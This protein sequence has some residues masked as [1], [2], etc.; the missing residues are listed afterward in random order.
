MKP[1]ARSLS[2][3]KG[4]ID[5]PSTNPPSLPFNW[6]LLEKY[7]IL[8][9]IGRWPKGLAKTEMVL[10]INCFEGG[11]SIAR[12]VLSVW[13]DRLYPGIYDARLFMVDFSV[14]LHAPCCFPFLYPFVL[15]V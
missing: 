12:A 15:Q 5:K 14:L 8:N 1:T 10:M 11:S 13:H 7:F 9:I 3:M 6:V 2:L 4:I